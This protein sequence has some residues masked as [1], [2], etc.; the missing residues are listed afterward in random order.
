M[1]TVAPPPLTTNPLRRIVDDLRIQSRPRRKPGPPG[2]TRFNLA[3]TNRFTRDPL[4]LLLELYERHGPIFRCR[5]LHAARS[6]SCSGPRPTTTSWSARDNFRWRDG[7]L[8]D[9]IPLIGDGLLTIDGPLPPA[10]ATQCFRRSTTTGSR[11][12]STRWSRRSIARSDRGAR[13][14]GRR[15]PWTRALA[16]RIAMRALFGIDPDR[17]TASDVARG[18]RARALATTGRD[19]FVQACAGPARRE[20]DASPTAR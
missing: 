2:P 15:L 14:R 4:P 9:L 7:R 16:L 20:A 5:V 8:G 12:P 17:A 13:R 10:R 3:R 6:S 18:V 11:C 19:C 1:G